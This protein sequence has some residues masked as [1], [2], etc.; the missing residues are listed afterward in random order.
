MKNHDYESLNLRYLNQDVIENFF[1]QIRSNGCANRNP[2]PEQFHEAFKTLLIC[3]ITSKHSIGSNCEETDGETT[4]A[5]SELMDLHELI[6]QSKNIDT[7]NEID[8]TEAAISL[9]MEHEI[10]MDPN[11]IINIINR[12]KIIAQ[13]EICCHYFNSSYV[14]QCIRHALEVAETKFINICH[15]PQLVE[16]VIKILDEQCFS[17]CIFHCTSFKKIL[18]TIISEEFITTWCIIINN[19]LFGRI[20]RN[21]DNYMYKSAQN[22]S[23]KYK[24]SK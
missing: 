14:S 19:I 24:H 1:S 21:F 2:T 12:N 18:L 4:L 17:T 3:N 13:C 23:K 10:F 5:L 22:L 15:E 6:K 16:K 20:E 9:F 11:K 8:F 7:T